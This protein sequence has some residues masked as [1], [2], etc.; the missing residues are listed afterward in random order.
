MKLTRIAAIVTAA[1]VLGIVVGNVVSVSAAPST[2]TAPTGLK[3][4]ATVRDAGGRLTD[5]VAKLTGL[6][7]AEVQ[8][9]R[10]AGESFADIAA[11]KGVTPAQVVDAAVAV[12]EDVLADKVAAGTITQ[13][14]ADAV[15]DRVETRV[16]D[17][18]SST[19]AC[20]GT[21]D[22]TGACATGG[23]CTGTGAGTGMMGGRGGR[24]AGSG[25]CGSG[26]CTQQAPAAQ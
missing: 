12:R 16:T 26:T 23:T 13:D 2:T 22:G 6:D 1:L 8:T 17:R 3:L 25:A 18:V 9:Q 24:G 15:I 5:V 19:T 14:Q 4:G 7:A 11:T 10:A 20:T 21:G